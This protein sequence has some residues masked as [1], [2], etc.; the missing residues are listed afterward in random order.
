MEAISFD[1]ILLVPNYSEIKTRKEID[2]KVDLGNDLILTTPIISANMQS[3]T[4]P[5]MAANMWWAGGMGILPR[6]NAIEEAI[7]D[8]NLVQE[9]GATCGVSL[10]IDDT[11]RY[12]KLYDAGARIFCIDVAHGHHKKVID[13]IKYI[14][15]G[16][17][18][19][20]AGNIAT[21]SGFYDLAN[22]GADIIKVG[23]GP[24]AACTTR[25]VTGFGVPQLT[26]LERCNEIR[27]MDFPNV[28]IISDGGIKN[29]GDIVKALVFGADAV[30]IGKLLAGADEAPLPGHYFGNA[31]RRVKDYRAPEGVEGM[32][33]KEGPVEDIIKRLSWGIKSGL[34][35]AGVE[36][37]EELKKETIKYFVIRHGGMTETRTRI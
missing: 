16:E 23:I 5:R 7:L 19:V 11:D 18:I 31:S 3:V 24:G 12:H 25:E 17:E 2:L 33:D 27:E 32:V 9:D 34:S 28:K 14:S 26:A 8:F 37:I 10:G 15:A 30:M 6:F 1:D 20:I 36:S 35:Y 13:L 29:S 4:G 21:A 22:A